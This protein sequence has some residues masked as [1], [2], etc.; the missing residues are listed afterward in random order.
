MPVTC[1]V[2]DCS[3]LATA[4]GLC[5]RHYQLARGRALIQPGERGPAPS[6]VVSALA[7]PLALEPVM[8]SSEQTPADVL[9]PD[10]PVDVLQVEITPD[11]GG[12]ISPFD[13]FLR[14][15]EERDL[16]QQRAVAAQREA[17]R[18]RALGQEE[19]AR[20]TAAEQEIARLRA[21]EQAESA[22]LA[23]ARHEGQRWST[24]AIRAAWEDQDWPPVG[25]V[26][27]MA[28]ISRQIRAAGRE[29]R[30]LS[31]VRAERD[32]ARAEASSHLAFID[33]LL[34]AA[35]WGRGEDDSDTAKI[36]HVQQIVTERASWKESW[37]RR[38]RELASVLGKKPEDASYQEL[39]A[40]VRERE[41]DRTVW[42]QRITMMMEALPRHL[43]PGGERFDQMV[44]GVCEL[45]RRA[46]EAVQ[47][48]A[49]RYRTTSL[50][51]I[52][53]AAL[54]DMERLDAVTA[55]L[56]QLGA[57]D[58]EVGSDGTPDSTPA[59]RVG[60]LIR[61][62][63][64]AIHSALPGDPDGGGCEGSALDFTL[65]EIA[66]GLENVREEERVGAAPAVVQT[67]GALEREITATPDAGPLLAMEWALDEAKAPRAE[68]L[69]ERIRLLS[70]AHARELAEAT[71]RADARES[72]LLGHL[73]AI[74]E[75]LNVGPPSASD[76]P[77]G[78]AWA[79]VAWIVRARSELMLEERDQRVALGQLI[80][81]IAKSTGFA[82]GP[83]LGQYG[84]LEEHIRGLA[85][86]A[87]HAARQEGWLA[88]RLADSTPVLRALVADGCG[89]V[90]PLA[91]LIAERAVPAG[92]GH[93]P[94]NERLAVARLFATQLLSDPLPF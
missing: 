92:P 58:A 12:A 69:V 61:F 20:L 90:E 23:A 94:Y 85:K 71:E 28:E 76:V 89:F 4:R 18:L 86:E 74:R 46:E 59:T 57:P 39:L 21:R 83:L 40:I 8:P 50:G 3:A 9:A 15:Y 65:A 87:A 16:W 64:D 19:S 25:G 29:L 52:V 32:A 54:L 91:S 82:T 42:I 17:E 14:A 31:D 78:T 79:E 26:T 73:G 88:E 62:W 60:L 41:G 53:G 55:A 22:Q 38:Q 48:L 45:L 24:Q 72:E 13:P 51:A 36:A 30:A 84:P 11:A 68:S 67:S 44:V 43:F 75:A 5:Q 1:L 33:A 6:S 27:E 81:R 10:E 47:P 66:Q 93:G 2:P 63:Q 35:G 34:A 7:A 80:E 70:S 56:D 77:A 37:Q 49:T